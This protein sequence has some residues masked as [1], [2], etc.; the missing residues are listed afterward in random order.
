LDNSVQTLGSKF[1]SEGDKVTVP[2][3]QYFVLGDNRTA[4]SDSRAWGF[5][6]KK[7]IN[8]RAWFVYW[9]IKMAGAVEKISYSF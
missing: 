5:V 7:D 2:T 6:P 4:S 9:P 3:E 1:L 8:G